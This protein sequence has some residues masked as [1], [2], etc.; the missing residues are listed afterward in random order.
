M[1]LRSLVSA[2]MPN[3]LAHVIDANILNADEVC[4]GQKME[5]LNSI[6]E[7]ALNCTKQCPRERSSIREVLAA[8]KKIKLQLLEFYH[9]EA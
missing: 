9:R 3:G 8:L 5:C 6:M 7:M 1:N 4:Y 2:S